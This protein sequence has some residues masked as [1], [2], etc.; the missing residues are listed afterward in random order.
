MWVWR[1]PEPGRVSHG[2][3]AHITE[4]Q[5]DTHAPRHTHRNME[6]SI[7]QHAGCHTHGARRE[8][9][10]HVTQA[11]PRTHPAAHADAQ[12]RWI[13]PTGN[14]KLA[15][16]ELDLALASASPPCFQ[17]PDTAGRTAGNYS[18]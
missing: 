15:L 13:R 11:E 12:R 17:R 14:C 10:T 18:T 9:H 4:S 6:P 1:R 7:L 2:D 5:S 16:D 3:A 8:L